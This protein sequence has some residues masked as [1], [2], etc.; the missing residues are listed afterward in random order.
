MII[1][2]NGRTYR[3]EELLAHAEGKKPMDEAVCSE[4]FRLIYLRYTY[5]RQLLSANCCQQPMLGQVKQALVD[6]AQRK[7]VMNVYGYSSEE[8]DFYISFTERFNRMV[9]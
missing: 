1:N 4:A 3:V 9:R 6:E 7:R 8:I 5:I 2:D